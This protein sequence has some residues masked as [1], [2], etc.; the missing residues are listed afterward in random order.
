MKSLAYSVLLCAA[1]ALIALMC[2]ITTKKLAP[3]SGLPEDNYYFYSH[4]AV[5]LEAEAQKCAL[6]RDGG[7]YEFNRDAARMASILAEYNRDEYNRQLSIR[8]SR[9]LAITGNAAMFHEA[10]NAQKL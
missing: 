6:V 2:A 5:E 4:R 3:S 7:G 10:Y 9:A 8:L 1:I